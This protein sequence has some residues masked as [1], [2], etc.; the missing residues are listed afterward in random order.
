MRANR[1][2]VDQ[3]TWSIQAQGYEEFKSNVRGYLIIDR[4][5]N[6]NKTSNRIKRRRKK[7]R[8]RLSQIFILNLV[9]FACLLLS[10][11]SFID[12]DH[13]F[14]EERKGEQQEQGLVPNNLKVVALASKLEQWLLCR[15]ATAYIASQ[16]PQQ[17]QQQLL[18]EH[19]T[20]IPLKDL[21]GEERRDRRTT[22]NIEL[23][24]DNPIN[25]KSSTETTPLACGPHFDGHLCWP[26]AKI[27]TKI[28]LECPRLLE[29]NDESSSS[30]NDISRSVK[31]SS[32]EENFSSSQDS[33]IES[34]NSSHL[35]STLRS[36]QELEE[37][38][39]KIT[40]NSSSEDK[41][42]ATGKFN[43]DT[44][45]ENVCSIITHTQ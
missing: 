28:R 40:N 42:N 30:L 33:I 39:R 23:S 13:D 9:L 44:K 31:G 19:S 22:N 6:M 41:R 10:S 17:Q 16:E 20:S 36:G 27:S 18:L 45:R 5:N 12:C 25:G 8:L 21:K 32:K 2:E 26:S 37:Q 11:S 35:P 4:R 15:R 34:I 24:T 43:L 38:D 29:A 7:K 3:K 14:N 1:N